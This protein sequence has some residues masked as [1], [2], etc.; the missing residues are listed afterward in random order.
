MGIV[1][2]ASFGISID[3]YSAGPG[4]DLEHPL[5]VGGEALFAWFLPTHTWSAVHGGD[6]G[7]TGVDDDFARRGFENVGAWIIGRNMFGPVRGPWPDETW[8]G[9]WGDDPPFH[10]PVFVLTHY[11]RLPVVMQG[12]TTFHFI[13]SGIDVALA[14]AREAADGRDVR[15]GGGGATIRAYLRAGLVDEMHLAV[16]PS[17]LGSGEALFYEMNLLELG[18][19]VRQTAATERATHLIVERRSTRGRRE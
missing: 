2:V 13:G 17:L 3:G 11:P 1:R 7:E 18:Y 12:G 15:I 6:G 16:V 10:T 5:G 9:W 4:Q 14:R 8:K 19:E